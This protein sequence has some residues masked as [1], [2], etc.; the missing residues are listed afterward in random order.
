MIGDSLNQ[1]IAHALMDLLFE[2]AWISYCDNLTYDLQEHQ[3]L[4]AF[5]PE[6]VERFARERPMS[7]W[8]PAL[9]E[10]ALAVGL[11]ILAYIGAMNGNTDVGRAYRYNC[12]L[13]GHRESPRVRA[14]GYSL[15]HELIGT[16]M[17][18]SDDHPEH[19]LKIPRIDTHL[20]LLGRGDEGVF[21]CHGTREPLRFRV[22]A[23]RWCA[24][25]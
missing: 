20:W 23:D 14:F 6:T 10:D 22:P 5:D 9:P 2:E 1:E 21:E 11:G 19:G 24:L 25:P 13:S 3:V 4:D 15:A 18:W 12:L 7:G 8:C 17:S 16:G